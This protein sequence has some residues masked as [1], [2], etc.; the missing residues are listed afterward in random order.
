MCPV[1]VLERATA[2]SRRCMRL[3]T[4][5][6]NIAGGQIPFVADQTKCLAVYDTAG[7]VLTGDQI[8]VTTCSA[9][10]S[11]QKWSYTANLQL[12][13]I[14]TDGS[15]QCMQAVDSSGNAT[16]ASGSKVVLAPCSANALPPASPYTPAPQVFS[17]NDGGQFQIS[18]STDSG[19]GSS[20]LNLYTTTLGTDAALA[21]NDYVQLNDCG[22]QFVPT[23]PVG[24]ARP[25]PRCGRSSW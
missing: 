8:Y 4:T 19:L 25:A 2:P 15:L 18:N 17:Y 6:Q 24:A 22:S 14:A 3:S 12:E 5:N 23:A 20:C 1:P 11:Q 21:A 9:T 13:T 16:T 7:K 10:S